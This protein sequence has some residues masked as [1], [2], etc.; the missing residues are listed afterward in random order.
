MG[1]ERISS[2]G[3]LR[4]VLYKRWRTIVLKSSPFRWLAFIPKIEDVVWLGQPE[5]QSFVLPLP[6]PA[7]ADQEGNRSY[8]RL[9]PTSNRDVQYWNASQISF[10]DPFWP[11]AGRN[12]WTRSWTDW[13][14]VC[15]TVRSNL[16]QSGDLVDN[17]QQ[18]C[19]EFEKH[20]YCALCARPQFWDSS[21]FRSNNSTFFFF[22]TVGSVNTQI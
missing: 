21:R 10:F 6:Q 11:I 18:F 8:V 12:I 5:Q 13:H 3:T 22:K 7:R 17:S 16:C 20:V 2:F 1:Q 14:M 9:L 15:W 19:F 4:W